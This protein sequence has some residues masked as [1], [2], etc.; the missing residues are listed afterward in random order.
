LY[1]YSMHPDFSNPSQSTFTGNGLAHPFTVPAYNPYN[2][3]CDPVNGSCIPEPSGSGV[4][5]LADRLMYRFAYW[6]DGPLAH[7][8]STP[9]LPAP[10]QHWLV[11]HTTTASGGQAGMRWY[12]ITAPIRTVT[13]DGLSLFQ[14]GTFAPD[15]NYRWMGSIARDKVGDI[16]LGYSVSSSTM[17]P[18]IAFTGRTVNDPLG[19]M[20]AEQVIVQ[21]AGEQVGTGNRWGDYSSMSIDGSDGCTFWYA[22]EYYT[23]TASFDWST[24]LASLKFSNC[25]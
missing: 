3:G 14:S 17:N 12:E 1:L 4:G 9:P 7:I 16:A 21:G 18:A 20:E 15:S 25:H 8:S 11:T 24:R 19:Q 6:D 5:S 10:A 23:E 22:Q 2:P 13:I